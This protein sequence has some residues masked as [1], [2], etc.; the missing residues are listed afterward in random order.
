MFTSSGMEAAPDI[1]TI[2][3][4]LDGD[5]SERFP[6]SRTMDAHNKGASTI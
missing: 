5:S 6:Q 1:R 2:D 4:S 3:H